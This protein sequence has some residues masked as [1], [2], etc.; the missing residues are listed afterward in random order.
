MTTCTPLTDLDGRQWATPTSPTAV[1]QVDDD[2]AIVS[3]DDPLDADELYGLATQLAGAYG[4]I[5]PVGPD[6][7]PM[8]TLEALA[9]LHE[10]AHQHVDHRAR[11]IASQRRPASIAAQLRWA[12]DDPTVTDQSGPLEV[13]A[14]RRAQVLLDV[15]AQPE[16]KRFHEDASS[17]D[18]MMAVLLAADD[19]LL[20]IRRGILWHLGDDTQPAGPARWWEPTV[21]DL[22]HDRLL[23]DHPEPSTT[24]LGWAVAHLERQ[25]RGQR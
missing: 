16:T 21:D 7:Y 10:R 6:G 11:H 17:D 24:T 9:A 22:R 14:W 23:H 4:T 5:A 1:T 2:H 18:T 8:T 13:D 15:A 3:A 25:E 20:T 12:L 19:G